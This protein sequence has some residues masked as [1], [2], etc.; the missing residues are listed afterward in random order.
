ML[1]IWMLAMSMMSNIIFVTT[2]HPM[3]MIIMII[4]QTMAICTMSGMLME[5]F[6]MSYILL[7]IFLGGMMVLF[8]YITSIASNVNMSLD[9]NRSYM[10][11]SMIVVII[12]MMYFVDKTML[13]QEIFNS[14][15]S[16]M[17]NEFFPKEMINQLMNMFN[18]PNSILTMLVIIYLFIT[19]TAV[20]KI[21]NIK[22]GPIRKITYE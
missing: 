9:I 18:L 11:I 8:V 4:T 15:T 13:N 14:E 17:G 3:F 21:T 22:Y 5:S 1:L 2:S 6:W 20:I 16:V 7:L 19:L 10:T 12:M